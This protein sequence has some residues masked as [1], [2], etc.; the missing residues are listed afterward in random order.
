MVPHL[1]NAEVGACGAAPAA[2]YFKR[3]RRLFFFFWN[4]GKTYLASIR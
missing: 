1:V 4:A 2:G 3:N